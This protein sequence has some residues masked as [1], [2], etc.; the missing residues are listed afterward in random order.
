[1]HAGMIAARARSYALTAPSG[2]ASRLTFLS[3]RLRGSCVRKKNFCGARTR[4]GTACLC[5]A[6]SNGRCRLHGGLSTG[7][8]T[9][10]GRRR[11]LEA[12]RQGWLRWSQR[13]TTL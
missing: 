6:L 12:L 5:M 10:E 1:M 4:R 2:F 11:S 9:G 3:R 7:P 13:G 8:R